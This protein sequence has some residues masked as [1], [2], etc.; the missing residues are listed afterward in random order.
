M[1]RVRAIMDRVEE[2]PLRITP[3]LRVPI[4]GVAGIHI[5]VRPD[6]PSDCRVRRVRPGLIDPG[7]VALE[8][9]LDRD[10]APEVMPGA[11]HSSPTGLRRAV[12]MVPPG[13][14]PKDMAAMAKDRI[15]TPRG[16]IAT[17]ITAA[18]LL[19][20]RFHRKH[21]ALQ[22]VRRFPGLRPTAPIRLLTTPGRTATPADLRVMRV[23]RVI[24]VIRV[25]R[26]LVEWIDGARRD[27]RG[28]SGG[29]RRVRGVG[30]LMPASG[31]A[32]HGPAVVLAP[33]VAVGRLNRHGCRRRFGRSGRPTRAGWLL[34]FC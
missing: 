15:A 5:P 26:V 20:R 10:L 31:L 19:R 2:I 9:A 34:I 14:M 17:A 12:A 7:P 11:C 16:R 21:P 33:V 23:T 28:L 13:A 27:R 6:V 30:R 32:H 29:V 8:T 3:V 25:I 1:D 22:A 18:G 24:R 4:S